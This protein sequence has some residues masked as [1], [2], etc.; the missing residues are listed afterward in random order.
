MLD[1]E[2]VRIRMALSNAVRILEVGFELL[3]GRH[4]LGAHTASRRLPGFAS[5]L[6]SPHSSTRNADRDAP[7]VTP[8]DA[9]RMNAGMVG[10]ASEPLF[11]QRMIPQ[12]SEERRVGKEGRVLCR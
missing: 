5:I 7:G 11:A 4:V 6:S 1:P 9:D 8:V 12:R 2:Y 10:A 3:F